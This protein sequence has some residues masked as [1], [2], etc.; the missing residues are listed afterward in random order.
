V[1][2]RRGPRRAPEPGPWAD[3]ERNLFY[4]RGGYADAAG[5]AG[6]RARLVEIET[7]CGIPG[8]RVCYLSVP[9]ALIADC[10]R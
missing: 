2:R 8:N 10:A 6:L 3:F 9:P 1:T 7:Q 4:V 5:Y